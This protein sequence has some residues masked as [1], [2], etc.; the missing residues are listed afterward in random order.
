MNTVLKNKDNE[1]HCNFGKNQIH[2]NHLTISYA[3][4]Q[5][6]QGT[7]TVHD[8]HFTSWWHDY[9]KPDSNEMY[10]IPIRIKHETC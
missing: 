3:I 4:V 10:T 6:C 8:S 7:A 1:I 5:P 9:P 2:F